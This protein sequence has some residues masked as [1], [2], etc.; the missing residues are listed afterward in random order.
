MRSFR[1]SFG[2]CVA[3]M[4]VALSAHSLFA[5]EP[6]VANITPQGAKRGGDVEITLVGGNLDDAPE[7][8]L[9]QPGIVVKKVE[10]IKDKA[11]KVQANQFKAVLSIA[12]DCTLGNHPLRVRTASGL[13]TMPILF[14]VG[15]LNEVE[16]KEPNSEF[17]SPQAIPLNVTVNGSIQNEDVDYFVVE[18]KKGQRISAEVEGIR[19]G[20]QFFDPYL[21]ILDM[22]RFEL[23]RSDDAAVVWH[24]SACSIVAPADGKYV[25]MLR[26]STFSASSPYRLH[27][28]TFPRPSAMVPAG[29]KPGETIDVTLYG[30]P[31][32]PIKQKFT[33]PK[34]PPFLSTIFAPDNKA[35]PFF[36]QDAG[37]IAPSP[38][39]FRATPWNNVV[40]V[41]P[42]DDRTQATPCDAPIAM[43]GRIE[44]P[45]DVDHF[46][47]KATKGQVFDIRV[48]A[49]SI[50]SP[51][52]P[53]LT[54]LRQSNGGGTGSNDDSGSPDSYL[55]FT[56][57]ADDTYAV[58]IKDML[59]QGGPEFAYRV[60]VTPVQPSVVMTVAE[61]Q[62]YI[63]VV[64]P[65]A[66]GN[67]GAL[68]LNVQRTNWGGDLKLDIR[69]LPPGMK[70]ETIPIAGNLA[71]VPV[72][73]TAD[74]NAAAKAAAVD[75]IATPTDPKAVPVEGHLQQV[76][77]I[78]RGQ[79]NRPV[80]TQTIERLT[81]GVIEKVPFKIEIVEPKV[82]LVRNGT[83]DL[84]VRV[85]REK[86]FKAPIAIRMLYNPPGVS[87][88]G[89]AQIAE[90]QNE[91]VIP[92]TA[93]SNAEMK[94]FKIVVLGVAGV[95]NGSIEVASQFGKLTIGQPFYDFA[96]KAGA[97][98]QGKELTYVAQITNNVPFDGKATVQL[99][100]LP[101]ETTSAPIEIT[102]DSTEAT[103]V[104]KTTAKSPAGRH[105]AIY[106][107][108]VVTQN[109]EPIKHTFGPG[110]IRIDAP[111]PPKPTAKPAEV[112]PAAVAAAKPAAKPL[113]R[114]EML[115]QQKNEPAGNNK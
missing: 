10:P 75:L 2:G 19:L 26:E 112:K 86:D 47:F 107:N 45:G 89:S 33:V 6:R 80:Y 100:G 1:R 18:A 84:K 31:A 39:V 109:G 40:E 57:P 72:L 71:T 76:S 15:A 104:V 77:L 52:D 8:L 60:E 54:I 46:A 28:G 59:A 30:D 108:L 50:R 96:F 83:L 70:F 44:K 110:E 14:S 37:G 95:G 58:V 4:V 38:L 67:R 82:P 20:R 29:G 78:V 5:A 92:I 102:K 12:P 115:R 51:L 65:V 61:K 90:G 27:V 22:D 7:I 43:N 87:S 105:K 74:E 49:R 85:T 79:N 41:E 114:L 88:S 53:V 16:D 21:A 42:N 81:T 11:G 113:S 13:Q 55:R 35:T 24:D 94:D 73:F 63:D 62:Q 32:G 48:H 91:G 25:V 3:A 69:G 17:A 106:C 99:V 98:E 111:L 93:G 101:A 9:Y 34:E 56:A 97:T 103:F 23:A 36:P 64:M 66:K 68:M